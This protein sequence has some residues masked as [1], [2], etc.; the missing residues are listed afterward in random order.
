MKYIYYKNLNFQRL[1]SIMCNGEIAFEIVTLWV[2][3][4][5]EVVK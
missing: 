5:T 1:D 2:T 3:R 4:F